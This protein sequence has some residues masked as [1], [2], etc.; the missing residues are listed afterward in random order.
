MCF[1]S[2]TQPQPVVPRQKAA[3]RYSLQRPRQ[4]H[5]AARPPET[6]G[7]TPLLGRL[8]MV[9]QQGTEPGAGVGG[10]RTREGGLEGGREG[11]EE[12]AEQPIGAQP[13]S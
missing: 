13:I 4:R 6:R 9:P 1:A 8:Q 7:G 10:G 11:G 2:L 12:I 5:R 3:A